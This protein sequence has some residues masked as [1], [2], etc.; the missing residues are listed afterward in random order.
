MEGEG[1]PIRYPAI[2]EL[3]VDSRDRYPN[4]AFL[5]LEL[6][7]NLTDPANILFPA[8]QSLLSGY[9]TRIALSQVQLQWKTPNINPRNNRF[10]WYD[11]GLGNFYEE[12]LPV[13]FYDLSGL[14]VSMVRVM[15]LATVA[16]LYK[17][18]LLNPTGTPYLSI[19]NTAGDDWGFEPLQPL[20][21]V[22]PDTIIIQKFFQ[23]AGITNRNTHTENPAVIQS[24]GITA[25]L[26]YTTYIDFVSDRLA[27]FAK[28][29]DG[30][31]R[32][33]LGQTNVLSRIYLTPFN[34][35]EQYSGT[36]PTILSI[37]YTTPKYIRWNA[38]EYI[39]DFDLVL[40]DEFG[41]QLW[42][43]KDYPEFTTEYQLTIQASET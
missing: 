11:D 34:T 31:T 3:E 23:L 6:F 2:A 42:W 25:T 16:G 20:N 41:D 19:T 32:Q 36:H 39:N 17:V 37:D 26:A 35:H 14:G 12:V 30:M 28:V 8:R 27:K 38:G 43:D 24:F 40:Y 18:D 1:V 15:N 22:I 9:F 33:R 7:N 10:R 5:Q 13:G 4:T 29:K 21:P